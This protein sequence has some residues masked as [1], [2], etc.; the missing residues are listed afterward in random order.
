MDSD[1]RKIPRVPV[2]FLLDD[3]TVEGESQAAC[4]GVVKNITPNGM[5]LETNSKIKKND[6]LQ[7]AFT[8][9]NTQKALNF[10]GKIC[11]VESEK[12]WSTA[13]LEFMD[14]SVEQREAIMEYLLTLGVSI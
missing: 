3:M 10:E 2:F 11:W 7:L 8:L 14:L 12:A 6:I 5:L 13:G 1:R 4:Q 9:P